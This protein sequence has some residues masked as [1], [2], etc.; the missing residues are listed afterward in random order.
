MRAGRGPREGW[1]GRTVRS[2]GDG[3]AACAI[4]AGMAPS[5]AHPPP[6]RTPPAA[7]PLSSAHPGRDGPAPRRENAENARGSRTAGG[8][9]GPNC[10]IQGGMVPRRVRSERAWPRPPLIPRRIAHL[11]RP[12][13]SSTHLG[14]GGHRGVGWAR[15]PDPGD[16]RSKRRRCAQTGGATSTDTGVRP[17]PGP[18]W[19]SGGLRVSASRSPRRRG[20]EPA[21]DRRGRAAM[22][23]V[24]A[25]FTP[26]STDQRRLHGLAQSA[27]S[28]S[29]TVSALIR[30]VRA[31]SGWA[32]SRA[33]MNTNH[34]NAP[35]ALDR[36]ET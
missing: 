33:R 12:S 14:R 7:I 10:A 31:R 2:K 9:A 35:P 1:R 11:R 19:V 8:L 17:W 36:C 20:P 30:V 3:S 22:V 26:A 28:R 23:E 15:V 34:R 4:R 5:A 27:T 13:P 6:N 32:R 25:E 29:E 16:A 24:V 18:S 21:G